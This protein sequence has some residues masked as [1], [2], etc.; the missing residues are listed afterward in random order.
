MLLIEQLPVALIQISIVILMASFVQSL[1]GFGF[2]IIS[3]PIL[4]QLLD[5]KVSVQISLLLGF[6]ISA[7]A[8]GAGYQK[9]IK[10]DLRM[11]LLLGSLVGIPIGGL[12]LKIIDPMALRVLVSVAGIVFAF[13]FL[14]G[15]SIQVSHETATFA[16]V[17]VI[18]GILNSTTSMGGVVVAL[19]LA[20]MGF[21]NINLRLNM[22]VY[23]LLTNIVTISILALTGV[24]TSSTLILGLELIPALLVGLALGTWL[25]PRVSRG[26]FTKI[27][28]AVVLVAGISG[29]I[30]VTFSYIIL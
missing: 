11:S 12:V 8:L 18:S 21:D 17:G 7:A 6:V 22:L 13:L 14:R 29:L 4:V 5:P 9:G 15:F 1:T 23:L 2:A 30:S 24:F 3:V 25:F 27:V 19:F 26:V 28:L 16:I 20:N 10:L